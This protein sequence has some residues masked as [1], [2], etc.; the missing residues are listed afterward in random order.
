MNKY[1]TAAALG[2]VIVALFAPAAR[3][4]DDLALSKELTS[5]IVLQGLPCSKIVTVNTQS[6]RDYLVAC[7]DG[8][9]YEI[10][11][12]SQGKLIARALGQKLR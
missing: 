5:V 7:Q 1:L 4:G 10:A 3:A 6:E 9:N 8:N 11:A 12:N 2:I